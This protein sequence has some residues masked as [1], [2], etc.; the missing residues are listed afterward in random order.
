MMVVARRRAMAKERH[1]RL[2]IGLIVGG[3][4]FIALGLW[5]LSMFDWVLGPRAGNAGLAIVG[6]TMIVAGVMVLLGC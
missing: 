2:G 6:A 5:V 1:F 4:A 3:L